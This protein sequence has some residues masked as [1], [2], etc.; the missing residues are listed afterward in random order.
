MLIHKLPQMPYKPFA[1]RLA[2]LNA[3]KY[4]E[5]W[6]LFWNQIQNN[7]PP[8][9]PLI[10]YVHVQLGNEKSVIGP[11]YKVFIWTGSEGGTRGIPWGSWVL[12]CIM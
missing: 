10:M 3:G 1:F 4:D 12:K 7:L 8:S 5:R 6:T 11:E 2:D 9:Q